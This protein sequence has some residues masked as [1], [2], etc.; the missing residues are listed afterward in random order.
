MNE[1]AA[2]WLWLAKMMFRAIYSTKMVVERANDMPMLRSFYNLTFSI[3]YFKNAFK[4]GNL[5]N[6][7]CI[8]KLKQM[9]DKASDHSSSKGFSSVFS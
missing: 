4:Y 3:R 8:I 6:S 2:L 1:A 5:V 9:D 7:K